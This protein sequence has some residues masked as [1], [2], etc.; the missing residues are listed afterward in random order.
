MKWVTVKGYVDGRTESKYD[1]ASS[2]KKAPQ[3]DT[4]PARRGIR[5]R[6][7]EEIEYEADG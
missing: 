2:K 5:M 3:H 4:K 6:K 1:P 7:E